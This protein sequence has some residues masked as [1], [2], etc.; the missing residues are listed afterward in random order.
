LGLNLSVRCSNPDYGMPS[1]Q[2]RYR[3]A[4]WDEGPHQP[5]FPIEMLD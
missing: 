4:G 5:A 2:K 1:A 3:T